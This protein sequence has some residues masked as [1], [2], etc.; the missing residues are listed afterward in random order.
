[1]SDYKNNLIGYKYVRVKLKYMRSGLLNRS[2][3]I[4]V[5]TKYREN[6]LTLILK[7]GRHM[8]YSSFLNNGRLNRNF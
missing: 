5:K 1:M 3:N 8:L 7:D 6:S 2:R 4:K